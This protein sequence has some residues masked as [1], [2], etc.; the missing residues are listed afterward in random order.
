MKRWLTNSR[1]FGKPHIEKQSK[2]YPV[3][4]RSYLGVT[5]IVMWVNFWGAN[6]QGD[7]I[8]LWDGAHVGHGSADYFSRSQEIHFWQIL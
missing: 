8:D 4:S 2:T 7:H 6:M 1:I 5:G 3:T